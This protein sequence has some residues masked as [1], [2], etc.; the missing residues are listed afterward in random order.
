MAEA[1]RDPVAKQIMLDIAEAYDRLAK[2][3]EARQPKNS[4]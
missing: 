4:T 3:L 2:I 1:F